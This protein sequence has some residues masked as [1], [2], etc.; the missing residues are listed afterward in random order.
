MQMSWGWSTPKAL[1]ISQ[2]TKALEGHKQ[3]VEDV[4]REENKDREWEQTI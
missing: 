2:F 3:E 1:G 4:V